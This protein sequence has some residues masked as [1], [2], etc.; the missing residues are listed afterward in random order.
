MRNATI[1]VRLDFSA[2]QEFNV[3]IGLVD[4]QDCG[5]LMA[6]NESAGSPEAEKT[7]IAPVPEGAA[8]SDD[9]Q[10]ILFR[11]CRKS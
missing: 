4:A 1:L 9:N 2:T 8:V 3:P 5:W 7:S 10:S 6:G 11:L